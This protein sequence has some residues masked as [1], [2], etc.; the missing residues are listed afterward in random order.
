MYLCFFKDYFN[1]FCNHKNPCN[2][3]NA[4]RNQDADCSHQHGNVKRNQPVDA[5]V[6]CCQNDI[7]LAEQHKHHGATH[8]RNHH[9]GSRH[10]SGAK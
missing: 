9:R 2:H 7:I 1:D 10:N 5:I 8:A 6:D 3:T 4:E